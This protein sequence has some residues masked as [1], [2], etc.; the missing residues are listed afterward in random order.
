[1]VEVLRVIQW[2]S[3]NN[4]KIIKQGKTEVWELIIRDWAGDSN[5]EPRAYQYDSY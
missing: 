1:M 5:L 3:W 2:T 4:K